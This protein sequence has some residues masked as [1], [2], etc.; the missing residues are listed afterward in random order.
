MCLI[1]CPM[2]SWTP[3][4][5][6]WES[7]ESWERLCKS[8]LS[9]TTSITSLFTEP[10]LIFRRS[11]LLVLSLCCWVDLLAFVLWLLPSFSL[12]SIPLCLLRLLSRG[13]GLGALH[14]CNLL[15]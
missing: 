9:L 11:C 15:P 1:G 6:E 7:P 8:A 14:T 12:K 3:C 4:T 5:G 10:L 2:V 13:G